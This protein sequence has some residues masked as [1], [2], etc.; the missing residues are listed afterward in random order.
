MNYLFG[1][2]NSRRL[3]LSL[4]VDLVRA[5]TCSLDCVYCECGR[6]TRLTSDPGE[7]VPI[8]EVI[9]ELDR[10]LATAPA[11]DYIT[12]SGAGEPT[13]H[14]GIGKVIDH[15]G[16]RHPG[17]RIAVL[18]NGTMLHLPEVRRALLP[19]HI[20]V[21]SLDAVS[22][23][24]FAKML[25]PAA[26]I[27]PSRVVDG[28]AAFRREYHGR[29]VIEIFILP[30]VNDSPDELALLKKACE[31]ISPD[32]IELNT[33]YRPPAEDW[34]IPAGADVLS[35]IAKSFAP[36]P[37]MVVGEPLSG[38]DSGVPGGVGEGE[39]LALVSRRPCT[40]DDLSRGLNIP[41][42][43]AR[44]IIAALLARGLVRCETSGGREFYRGV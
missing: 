4:G 16:E 33:L 40:A 17:Y 12:F 41:V 34:A 11:L 3:G 5:K 42:G 28:I 14:S 21:P 27:S 44:R 26:G 32:A 23:A 2:V 15:L 6:T 18:T 39:V 7:Y 36:L 29:L 38:L 19:A 37:V 20:V 30:G 22:P 31:R 1:P 10:Y 25:R 43:E 13:L 8:D 24:V 9:D 35:E